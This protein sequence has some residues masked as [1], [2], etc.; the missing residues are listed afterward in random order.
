MPSRNFGDPVKQSLSNQEALGTTKVSVTEDVI[1]KQ[2]KQIV[3]ARVQEFNFPIS[4]IHLA[5]RHKSRDVLCLS[6]GST[7]QGF[8]SLAKV[9]TQSFWSKFKFA[10]K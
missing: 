3:G 10:E 4:S 9:D 8:N 6:L 5:L 2:G 7:F 1:T